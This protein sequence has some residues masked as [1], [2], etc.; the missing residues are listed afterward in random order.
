MADSFTPNLNLR[1]PE[2][3][4]ANDTWGGTAGLNNDMDLLDAVFLATGLGTS[5]GLHVGVGKVLNVE[6]TAL[7][8]DDTDLTKAATFDSSLI[9]TATLR[10]FQ[11]PDNNG[12]LATQTYVRQFCP[13]GTVF[14]GYYPIVPPG[15]VMVDGRTIGDATSGATNRANVD[16]QQ[17]FLQLWLA[18]DN[19]RC[20][21]SGGRGISAAADWA[22]HKT[23]TLPDHSGRGMAG[24]DNLSGTSAGRVTVAGSGI[25]A[26]IRG[27]AGGSQM[28]H[29]HSHA[30]DMRAD[31]N[32]VGPGVAA[33]WMG[34]GAGSQQTY[35][36]GTGN[37]QNVPPTIFVDVIIAL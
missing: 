14:Q 33:V 26:T 17:L 29:Q 8:A 35:L 9:T 12:V 7:F 4:S 11:F 27:N 25:D 23:L 24:R 37:G 16:C 6:G 20:P 32:S 5:V 36:A 21:V 19:T 31:I 13:T 2:V 15:F 30:V 1:K 34:G 18:C 3:G 10:T 22:A 28:L